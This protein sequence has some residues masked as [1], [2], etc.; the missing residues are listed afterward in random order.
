MRTIFFIV[1]SALAFYFVSIDNSPSAQWSPNN[2]SAAGILPVSKAADK[3]G[4]TVLTRN[5]FEDSVRN[6]YDMIGL[7][8]YDLDYNV[9][10]L[11]LIGY[12]SLKEEDEL[13]KDLVTIIDFNKPSTKKRFYTI[14]LKNKALKFYTYVAH[15]RNTGENMATS[16]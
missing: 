12:Y 3:S 13:N 4:K 10:R 7:E 1:L 2:I 6:L 8:S 11:G 15:G 9:F 16:F 14:D 5:N